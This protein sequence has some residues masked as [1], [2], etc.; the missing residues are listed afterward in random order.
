MAIITIS[1]GTFA[2]GDALSQCVADRLGYDLL[3]REALFDAAAAFGLSVAKLT[4]AM[5]KPPSFWQRLDKERLS[6]T[7][8]VRAIL[9]DRARKGNLV[10][11]GH[12]ANVLL[13]GISHVIRVRVIADMEFRIR[14]AMERMELTRD[15]AIAYVQKVDKDRAKWVRLLYGVDWN[16]PTLYDVVLNLERISIPR[17]CE[18]IAQMAEMGDFRPTAE[19]LQAVEDMALGS[20]VWAVLNRDPRTASADV[21]VTASSGILRVTGTGLSAAVLEA[22]P[23]VAS[24][25]DG[26]KEVRSEVL[27]NWVHDSA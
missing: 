3:S 19:S 22:I 11:H 17:A 26:V 10:Y 4:E 6:Y 15:D 18:I 8:Y 13:S 14:S 9:C 12:A 23:E 16:D 7:N 2:G 5:D 24:L 25:I 20:L 21:K 1:R 27:M